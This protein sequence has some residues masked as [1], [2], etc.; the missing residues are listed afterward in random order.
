MFI[1][2]VSYVP[3]QVQI[4]TAMKQ[5]IQLVLLFCLIG[6]ALGSVSNADYRG[7]SKQSGHFEPNSR[8]RQNFGRGDWKGL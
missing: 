6:L 8:R 7:L 1:F 2:H 3:L 4:K 5:Y